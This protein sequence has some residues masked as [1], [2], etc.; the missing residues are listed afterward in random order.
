MNRDGGSQCCGCPLNMALELGRWYF[1]SLQS[2]SAHSS[3][4]KRGPPPFYELLFGGSFPLRA[5]SSVARLSERETPSS[6]QLFWYSGE[7]NRSL[8]QRLLPSCPGNA[9]TA[10]A[11]RDFQSW[12]KTPSI[13]TIVSCL[14]A[15]TRTPRLT[16]FLRRMKIPQCMEIHT[17]K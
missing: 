4:A 16:S 14:P 11:R 10:G 7:G 13:K 9:R 8:F 3:V 2:I 17:G 15:E 6:K 5:W 1:T 12:S